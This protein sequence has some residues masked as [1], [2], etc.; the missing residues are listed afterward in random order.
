MAANIFCRLCTNNVKVEGIYTHSRDIFVRAKEPMSITDRLEG[1]G[2]T[3]VQELGKSERICN[4]Y[5]TI[6]SHLEHDLTA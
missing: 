5:V 2:L 4:R 6:L 1:I 3:V